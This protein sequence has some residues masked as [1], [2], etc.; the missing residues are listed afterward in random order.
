MINNTQGDTIEN[1]AENQMM[2]QAEGRVPAGGNNSKKDPAEV[3]SV[4]LT[5]EEEEKQEEVKAH[6]DEIA[7]ISEGIDL[8]PLV[9]DVQ[10]QKEDKKI[11]VNVSIIVSAFILI[12][13]SFA[14]II[15]NV[16][17][18]NRLADEKE[19]LSVLTDDI[20]KNYTDVINSNNQIIDRIDLYK[21]IKSTQYATDEV[22]E[23]FNDCASQVGN[24]SITRYDISAN[25]K[26]SIRGTAANLQ[27]VS[28]L[29]Y[30]LCNNNNLTGITLTSMGKGVDKVSFA[31]SGTLIVDNFL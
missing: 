25:S 18:K 24:V 12:V 17:F 31:F 26:I 19:Y 7:S 1:Q 5:P 15:V 29:W 8:V 27:D 6:A 3:E 10:A 30:I 2:N 9:T 28:K 22:V 16:S 13:V 20:R 23:F 4:I 11:K 14:I 21:E